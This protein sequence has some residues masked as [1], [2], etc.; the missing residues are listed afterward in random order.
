LAQDTAQSQ[1][2]KYCESQENDGVDVEH[3]GHSLAIATSG[4]RT[5]VPVRMTKPQRDTRF[6]LYVIMQVGP[7][8]GTP[9]FW[10]AD[11]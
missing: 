10:R 3:V 1:K 9:S 6:P 11:A 4:Q 5:P 8:S 7:S 2:N